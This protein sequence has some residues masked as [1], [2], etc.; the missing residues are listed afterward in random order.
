MRGFILDNL[1]FIIIAIFFVLSFIKGY[2]KGFIRKVVSIAT[3][4]VTII[5]TKTFTP[6]VV[7]TL[8]DMT[9]IEATVNDRIY[10]ALIKTNVFDKLNLGV[11]QG[12]FGTGDMQDMVRNKIAAELTSVA[13]NFMCGVCLFIFTFLVIKIIIRLLDFIDYIPVIGEINKLLGGV[14]GVVEA[15][16]VV[17]LVFSV[18]RVFENVPSIKSVVDNIDGNPVVNMIYNNNLIY[19]FFSSL[20]K[21]KI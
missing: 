8:K 20:F 19:N 12:F 13:L 10:E 18:I 11:L 15:L 7:E 14:S 1:I 3:I 16:L 5:V 9:N 4:I 2:E 21:P 6:T 17:W